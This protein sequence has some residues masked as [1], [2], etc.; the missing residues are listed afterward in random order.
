MAADMFKIPLA[1]HYP[2][3]FDPDDMGQVMNL[4]V[5]LEEF[6]AHHPDYASYALYDYTPDH[7]AAVIAPASAD[8]TDN[9]SEMNY[10]KLEGSECSGI[11]AQRKT[12]ERYE[13]MSEYVGKRVIDFHRL[14]SGA[15]MM[16][17]QAMSEKLI[18]AREQF[19][20]ALGVKPW[21]IHV[22]ETVDHGYRIR[23]DEGELTY[24][25]DLDTKMQTAVDVVSG[26]RGWFFR[27]YPLIRAI[28][29][30]Q[31]VPP[32]F[33]KHIPI[34][35]SMWRT[36]IHR[37]W[38]GMKLPDL[39]RE[40]GDYVYVDWEE[41]PSILV[42][43]SSK[44]GKSVTINSLIY[45]ALA[46]GCRLAVVDDRIKRTDYKW[47]RPWFI[48][49]GCGMD[50]LESICA[51]LQHILQ[52]S[53][54][55]MEEIDEAGKSNAW[56]MPNEWLEKNP[57]ILLVADEIAQWAN[58]KGVIIPDG[59]AKDDPTRIQLSYEKSLQGYAFV[60][61]QQVTQK[62]RSAGIFFL[63]ASQGA[64]E[65]SGISTQMKI[66]L[67][68]KLFMMPTAAYRPDDLKNALGAVKVPDDI[69]FAAGVGLGTPNGSAPLVYK[70]FFMEDKAHGVEFTDVLREH[71][72]HVVPPR[73]GENA[74]A[75]EKSD[76]I[77]TVPIAFSVDDP[78]E[79]AAAA[80]RI[81]SIEP[82]KVR[83]AS[84]QVLD[85][86]DVAEAIGL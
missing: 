10:I 72:L 49:K 20:K 45:M 33:P 55:R 26:T 18:A 77:A 31:G 46:A 42:T 68:T 40:T 5:I 85:A 82:V 73:G 6:K 35:D 41:S 37:A 80:D 4:T 60:K 14:P 24:N 81:Q 44:G 71:L 53:E 65:Q 23:W 86:T 19:A 11:A 54:R 34:L 2:D 51:T 39:G 28:T 59:L 78:A 58:P 62:A 15:W 27:A 67:L 75:W 70:S 57:F 61:L 66:N 30:Q 74:G 29:V 50:G 13:A 56:K 22:T 12:V 17:M 43:G 79:D 69:P 1:K 16:R 9:K 21:Q 47:C 38:F 64:T 32:K 8:P 36:D 7:T 63:L 52:I 76:I 48:D 83:D 3:G 25:G 84:G